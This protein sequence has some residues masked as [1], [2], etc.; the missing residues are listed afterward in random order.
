MYITGRH[1]LKY[2]NGKY[3]IRD[4]GGDKWSRW[5]YDWFMTDIDNTSCFSYIIMS[6]GLLTRKTTMFGECV[7][8]YNCG[9]NSNMDTNSNSKQF[10]RLYATDIILLGNMSDIYD[11]MP[12]LFENL[13]STTTIFPPIVIP[14]TLNESGMNMNCYQTQLD[15]MWDKDTEDVDIF[16]NFVR[17]ISYD[18]TKCK[19]QD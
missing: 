10:L 15:K 11:S 16:G 17:G 2:E 8:Y 1:N 12:K 6:C 7:F 14:K 19:E 9:G 5:N 4:T 13:P 18:G 3:T